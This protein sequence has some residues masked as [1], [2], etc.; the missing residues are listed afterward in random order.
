MKWWLC[1]KCQKKI[2]QYKEDGNAKNIY[3]K[4][5]KCKEI[6]EINIEPKSQQSN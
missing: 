5:K 1:P 6:I 3:I 2:L 4:C